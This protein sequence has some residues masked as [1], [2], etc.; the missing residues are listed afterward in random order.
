MKLLH[1][2]LL[3][4]L[5]ALA[6]AECAKGMFSLFDFR[7]FKQETDDPNISIFKE[8]E[9]CTDRSDCC[10]GLN[11]CDPAPAGGRH[12]FKCRK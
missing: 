7:N 2:F 9:Q 4:A 12:S 3:A 6:S 1:F 11:Y 5:T 10:E 8:G